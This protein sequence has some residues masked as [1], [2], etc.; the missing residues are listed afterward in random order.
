MQLVLFS[1]SR[2]IRPTH[3]S[4]I[5]INQFAND[6]DGWQICELAEIDS[7][8]GMAGAHQ[9]STFTRNE[10]ENMAWAYKIS[11][12][13]IGICQITHRERAVISRNAGRRAMAIINRDSECS[14]MSGFVFSDHWR[15]IEALGFFTWHR[16]AHDARRIAHDEGHLFRRAMHCCNDQ[17]ALVLTTVIIHDHNDFATLESPQ[18]INDLFLIIAHFSLNGCTTASV[19]NRPSVPETI[20]FIPR[21]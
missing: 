20:L 7:R 6:A 18:R 12:T 17:I 9:H 3:D 14:C 16:R 13:S 1:K 11:S 4:S 5:I 8:F 10:R 21:R 19:E 15:K 2:H